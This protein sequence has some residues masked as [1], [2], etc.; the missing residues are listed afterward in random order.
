MF[1]NRTVRVLLKVTYSTLFILISAGLLASLISLK[2]GNPLNLFLSVILFLSLGLVLFNFIVALGNDRE[3]SRKIKRLDEALMGSLRENGVLEEKKRDL[4]IQLRHTQKLETIGTLAGGMAHDFNNLLS[5]ILG[6]SD[7]ALSSLSKDDTLYLYVNEIVR[8]AAKAREQVEQV[9]YFSKQIDSGNRHIDLRTII[10]ETVMVLRPLIPSTVQFRLELCS[11]VVYVKADPGG[12]NQILVNLCTNGWQ[13]MEETGGTLTVRTR[14]SSDGSSVIMSVADTGTGI[15]NET[16]RHMF[17]PFYSTRTDKS[18]SGL[19]LSVVQGIV[20]SVGG[21]IG[22]DTTPG[23]GSVFS[24][25]LPLKIRDPHKDGRGQ[26][27]RSESHIL[28]VDDDRNI[29]SMICNMLGDFGFSIELFNN[30]ADALKAF[31]EQPWKFNLVITDLTMPGLTG[32]ELKKELLK[33]REDI[34]VL[35]MTG[36]GPK[37]SGPEKHVLKKPFVKDELLTAIEDLLS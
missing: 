13:A 17:E 11:E 2:K 23:F 22:V 30:S 28:L 19:G 18:S 25:Y 33:V 37:E 34:P 29:T 12:V 8:A 5:P 31:R 14:L 26:I 20:T 10:E 1:K 35:I 6:Y 15:E 7:L 32:S 16:K 24:I 3:K 21:K 9:L 4:E 27:T 36:Y